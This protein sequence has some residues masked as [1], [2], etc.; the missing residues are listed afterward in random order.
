MYF[1]YSYFRFIE[2]FRAFLFLGELTS[3]QLQFPLLFFQEVSG[4]KFFPVAAYGK[5][6]QPCIDSDS[7]II[8]YRLLR[9]RILKRIHKDACIVS[10]VLL[11]GDSH[12]VNLVAHEFTM[13]DD[14]DILRFRDIQHFT[15]KIYRT[16][17]WIMK[18]LPI[19]L[20]LEVRILS[21]LL[22]KVLIGSVKLS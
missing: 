20:A 22:E 9:Q 18:G 10:S 5:G 15:F 3:E 14:W 7:G 4:R 17:L 2:C 6:F 13:K 1:R 16:T 12:I 21:V 19:V 8:R 11:L